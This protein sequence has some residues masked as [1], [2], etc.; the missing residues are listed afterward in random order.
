MTTYRLVTEITISMSVEVEADSL[1]EAMQ[2]A[3]E[4]PVQGLCH[5]CSHG[6]PECWNTSGEL[7]GDPNTGP[8][9]T[10][11]VDGEELTGAAFK[12]AAKKWRAG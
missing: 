2:K 9:N 5:Q 7:D 8:L 10:V 1:D 4:A 3:G 11:Y 6:E 12:R